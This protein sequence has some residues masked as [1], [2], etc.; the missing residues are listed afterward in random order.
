MKFNFKM[1]ITTL[2]KFKVLNYFGIFI[3]KNC[4][5]EQYSLFFIPKFFLSNLSEP[6][7]ISRHFKN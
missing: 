2:Y 1:L 7:E 6:T 3:K 4:F 5:W